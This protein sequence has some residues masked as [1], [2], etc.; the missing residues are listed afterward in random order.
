MSDKVEE[1]KGRAK[2]AVGA[3]TGQ[4]DLREEGKAQQEKVEAGQEAQQKQAEAQE[5][6]A[7]AQAAEAEQRRQQ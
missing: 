5:A 2:E 3:A 6:Q 1:A 4:D 7:E